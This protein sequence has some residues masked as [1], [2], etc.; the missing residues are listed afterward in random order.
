MNPDKVYTPTIAILA[1][2]L[3]GASLA[4]ASKAAGLCERVHVWARRTETRD[5]CRAQPWCDHCFDTIEEAVAQADLIWVCAPV[6][7]ISRLVAQ[8]APSLKHGAIVS[9][10]GSTK[11]LLV[12]ACE[13]A[14]A[15]RAHFI[16]SHP[17]AGSERSGL[18]HAD[19]LLYSGK[20]CFVTP[21]AQSDPAALNTVEAYWRALGMRVH[22]VTAIEHDRI[23]ACM[24]HLPHVVAATLASKISE[25]GGDQWCEFAGSGLMDTTRVAAG[26]TPMW[27]DILRHNRE[28]ILPFLTE[29]IDGLEH[30]KVHLEHGQF[31]AVEQVLQSG[32]AFRERLR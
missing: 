17:M 21:T 2:G 31:D 19:A 24:S 29:V 9:D 20:P 25:I 18:E 28:Q 7:A 11:E 23:V 27:M 32:K 13:R 12:G 6:G 5:Q 1:P 26:S 14:L 10:V 15:G 16:G 3:L 30:V 22:Q 4:A 8:S